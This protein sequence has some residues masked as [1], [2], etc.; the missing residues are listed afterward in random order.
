VAGLPVLSRVLRD[1]EGAFVISVDG[2]W[3]VNLDADLREEIVYPKR[4]LASVA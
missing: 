4:C 3:S 1:I 2:E